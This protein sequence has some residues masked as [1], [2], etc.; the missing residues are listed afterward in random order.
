MKNFALRA[1]LMWSVVP[2]LAA[3]GWSQAQ[4]T[5]VLELSHVTRGKLT[6]EAYARS[7]ALAFTAAVSMALERAEAQPFDEGVFPYA[8]EQ[9]GN[10]AYAELTGSELFSAGSGA[11][12]SNDAASVLGGAPAEPTQ[13]TT[14]TEQRWANETMDASQGAS[15]DGAHDTCGAAE[16]CAWAQSAE[17][18][19]FV[20]AIDHLELDP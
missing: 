15:R 2:A 19:A 16:L 3:C 14:Y 8:R 11:S 20:T 4:P 7:R 1:P 18:A 6:D 12:I 17:E 10:P 13:A 9:L 5:L